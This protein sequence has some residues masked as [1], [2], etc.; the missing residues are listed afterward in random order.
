MVQTGR[1]YIFTVSLDGVIL[2]EL[3]SCNLFWF[4]KSPAEDGFLSQE[5]IVGFLVQ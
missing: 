5:S 2:A 1:L 4:G 3:S